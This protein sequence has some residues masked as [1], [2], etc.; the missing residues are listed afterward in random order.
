MDRTDRVPV[1]NTTLLKMACSTN[2]PIVH[3]L[4]RE[5]MKKMF[6]A[7]IRK[8]LEKQGYSVGQKESQSQGQEEGVSPAPQVP[9]ENIYT[10]F[11]FGLYRNKIQ[12][13]TLNSIF[14]KLLQLVILLLLLIY[15]PEII[16]LL[17]LF[18]ELIALANHNA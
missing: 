12:R 13:V 11:L 2:E 4:N 5:K 17:T 16:Q 18:I 7:I 14:W 10:S 9:G 15:L 1:G 6:I 8:W 3:F